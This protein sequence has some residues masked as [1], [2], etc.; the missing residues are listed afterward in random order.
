MNTHSHAFFTFAAL[1]SVAGCGSAV[2]GSVFPDALYYLAVPALAASRGISYRAAQ[3]EVYRVPALKRA[4]D[5]IHAFPVLALVALAAY[6]FFPPLLM[7]CLGWASHLAI[8]F[9]THGKGS[10]PHFWPLIPWRFESP[11]SFYEADRFGRPFML[12]E[13]VV[14]LGLIAYFFR[15]GVLSRTAF[16]QADHR[17]A[18]LA[19]A[20]FSLVTLVAYVVHLRQRESGAVRRGAGLIAALGID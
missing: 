16:A 1:H 19:I 17:V 6:C 8:D 9:V 20:L 14:M 13:H 3:T 5:A 2:A 7:F 10:H 18:V 4:V 15:V 11:V 12:V